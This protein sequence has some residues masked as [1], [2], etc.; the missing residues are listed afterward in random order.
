MTIA[1][2]SSLPRGTASC[3]K[4]LLAANGLFL[5]KGLQLAKVW[6]LL[7]NIR[8]REIGETMRTNRAAENARSDPAHHRNAERAVVQVHADDGILADSHDR[9]GWRKWEASQFNLCRSMGLP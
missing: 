6:E 9:H 2:L 4:I 8:I 5:K 1:L 3:L 7:L